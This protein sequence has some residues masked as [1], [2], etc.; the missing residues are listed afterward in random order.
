MKEPKPVIV[1]V[2]Y[3]RADSLVRLLQSLLHAKEVSDALLII[4]IDNQEPLNYDVKEL[5]ESFAWPYGDKEVRYQ[6]KHLCM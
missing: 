3:N 2:A 5:A 1:V 4:S 6:E